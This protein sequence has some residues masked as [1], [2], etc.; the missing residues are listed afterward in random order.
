[1]EILLTDLKRLPKLILGFVIVAIGLLFSDKSNLGMLPWGVFHSGLSRLTHIKFGLIVQLIGI[2][3][4]TISMVLVK[5]RPGI[6]T[7]FDILLVGSSFDFIDSLNIIREVQTLYMQILYMIIG[8]ILICFGTA[9]YVSCKLGSGPRDGL[10]IG[11]SRLTNLSVK[12]TKPLIEITVVVVGFLLQGDFGVGTFVNAFLSGYIINLFFKML[13]YDPKTAT[14]RK[15]S[16]YH[17]KKR[18]NRRDYQAV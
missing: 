9:L 11:L 6:G 5:V 18:K 2:I 10:F 8:I 13:K 1:M 17:I 12:Y 14:Q 3:V 16:D 7:I 15:F 4:L